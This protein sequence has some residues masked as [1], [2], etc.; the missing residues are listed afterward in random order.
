MNILKTLQKAERKLEKEA[1]KIGLELSQ[2]RNAIVA[3]GHRGK[4]AK[5][6]KKRKMSAATR[7]KIRAAQKKRWAKIR[8]EKS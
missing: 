4:P 1:H 7:R 3:L 5:V 2:L 8:A 6:A